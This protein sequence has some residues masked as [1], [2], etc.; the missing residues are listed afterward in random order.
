MVS[1]AEDTPMPPYNSTGTT[2]DLPTFT[3]RD[4][5]RREADSAADGNAQGWL[6]RIESVIERYPWPTVL[7]ALG[8]GYVL[9]RRMR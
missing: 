1:S 8:L 6:A 4:P 7:I 9:A 3:D 2:D 5:L